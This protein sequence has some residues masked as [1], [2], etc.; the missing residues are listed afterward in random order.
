L[1]ELEL[2]Y[3]STAGNAD[4]VA[5]DEMLLG[6]TLEISEA[7]G[8]VI[9]PEPHGPL[10]IIV[11][12]SGVASAFSLTEHRSD[13]LAASPIGPTKSGPASS[14]PARSLVVWCADRDEDIYELDRLRRAA[15]EVHVFIDDRRTDANKGMRW[16][17]NHASDFNHASVIIQGSPPFVYAIT[18]TLLARGLQQSQLQSDVYEY[19][20]R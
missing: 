17:T 6:H 19:A 1:P 2:H 10:I 4:A 16:I 8:R 12:G 14:G 18:D 3:R 7:A 15:D 5:M 20:P 13:Q 11:G 9:F